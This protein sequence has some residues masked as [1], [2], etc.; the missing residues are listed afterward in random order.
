[1]ASSFILS[2]DIKVRRFSEISSRYR[3]YLVVREASESEVVYLNAMHVYFVDEIVS[4]VLRRTASIIKARNR[5]ATITAQIVGRSQALS[6]G[7]SAP[8][9]YSI[10]RL[11]T[12]RADADGY[13]YWPGV[14]HE[15]MMHVEPW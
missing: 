6:F 12:S 11:E 15:D 2:V 10:Q 8:N 3:E 7:R 13:P 9:R 5:I 4:Q 14:F 1:M